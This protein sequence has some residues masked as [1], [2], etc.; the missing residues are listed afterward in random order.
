MLAVIR[1]RGT[2]GIRRSIKDTFKMLHLE[3]K[4]TCIVISEAPQYLGM[5]KKVKDFVTWGDISEETLIELVKK[6]ARTKENG[7]L[8]EDFLKKNKIENIA[9]K[10]LEG[11]IKEIDIKP[12]FR[13]SPPSKGFKGSIKQ[14]YPK[15]VLGNRKEEINQLL[16]RMM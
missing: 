6:R 10:I 3:K 1:I 16:K 11:K 9:K 15:G 8:T 5:I 7:R 14:H 12:Y 4:N 13:L 2:V